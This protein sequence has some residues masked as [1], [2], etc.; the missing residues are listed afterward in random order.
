MV[1]LERNKQGTH[2]LQSMHSTTKRSH[3]IAFGGLLRRTGRVNFPVTG[4]RILKGGNGIR[5]FTCQIDVNILF[6]E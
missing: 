5:I 4:G 1:G 3:A 6:A 2:G